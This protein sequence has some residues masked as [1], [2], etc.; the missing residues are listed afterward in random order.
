MLLFLAA[1]AWP[2]SAPAGEL[3]VRYAVEGSVRKVNTQSG[4]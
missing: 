4:P 1:P 2:A 3:G